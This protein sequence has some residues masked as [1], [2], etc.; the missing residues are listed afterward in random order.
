MGDH[1]RPGQTDRDVLRVLRTALHR[2]HFQHHHAAQDALLHRQPD[3]TMRRNVLPFCTRLLPSI[4]QRREGLPQHLHHAL[5]NRLLPPIGRDH[6]TNVIGRSTAGK[7]PAL[8]HGHGHAICRADH[9]RSERQF[10]LP[11][12]AQDGAL[13]SRPVSLRVAQTSAHGPTGGRG[14]RAIVRQIQRKSYQ[15]LQRHRH[16]VHVNVDADS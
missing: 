6:P 1:G 7:V 8:H 3:H 12:D 9:R 4:A 5:L 11:G 13:D 10:S 16:D 2:Y 14:N 15:H